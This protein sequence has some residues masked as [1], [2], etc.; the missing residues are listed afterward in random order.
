MGHIIAPLPGLTNSGEGAC[1]NAYGRRAYLLT[2]QDFY[3]L[4]FAI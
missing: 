3:H 4:N 1:F 2:A